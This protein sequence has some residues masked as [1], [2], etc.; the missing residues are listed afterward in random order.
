MTP[1]FHRGGLYSGG[2]NPV[3]LRRRRGGAAADFDAAVVLDWVAEH[4]LT[5][6]IGAP[7]NLA[8]LAPSSRSVPARPVDACTASSRWARR[9]SA[10][11]ACA[12]SSCSRRGSS[13]ATAPRRRSGTRSCARQ[14]CRRTPARRAGL[15][16]RRRRRRERLRGP[17]GRPGRPRRAGRQGGR[18]G[19]RA[20]AEVRLRVRE[21][22]RSRTSAN[23]STAGCTRATSPS[24][25]RTST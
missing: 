9:W 15:H 21:P 14:T 7:T 6:L 16:G 2:P 17:R 5:F 4:E 1:W 25:T 18:R 12:T 3:V 11:P 10:R 23:S 8:M 13:T 24:G 20:H 22:A 19:H